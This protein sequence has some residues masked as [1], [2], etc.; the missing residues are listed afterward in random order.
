M[1]TRGLTA[2]GV[3]PL[4][5]LVT[6]LRFVILGL[7]FGVL[8]ASAYALS[9]FGGYGIYFAGYTGPPGFM[10]FVTIKTMIILGATIAVERFAPQIYFRLAVIIAYILSVI[11]WLSGWAWSASVAAL[12]LATTCTS[13]LGSSYC[14][15]PGSYDVKFG[16]S[17]AAAAGL[18]AI[19]WVLMIV[20]L[21]FFIRACLADPEGTGVA[22]AQPGAE[23]G[24]VKHEVSSTVTPVPTAQQPYAPPQAQYAPPQA[25]Y[26]YGAPA[27]QPQPYQAP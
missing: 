19:A 6:I 25:Q 17:M 24:N 11:F 20:V 9:L 18:G 3:P 26:Q 2:R 15:G 4:P 27:A 8:V 5:F 13:Y 7:S 10:I 1:S 16:A 21:V 12:F 23:L 14:S 22:A